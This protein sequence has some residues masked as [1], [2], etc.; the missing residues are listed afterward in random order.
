MFGQMHQDFPS[1]RILRD[2]NQ[3]NHPP[4]VPRLNI[5][6]NYNN[7]LPDIIVA[8]VNHII[9]TARNNKIRIYCFNKLSD[10]NFQ[11]QD[12]LDLIELIIG[13]TIL[14]VEY[15]RANIEDA[16]ND[17][18]ER[19]CT[20]YASKEV[21]NNNNLHQYITSR[22]HEDWIRDNLNE[23]NQKLNMINRLTSG[24]GTN[25]SMYGYN[26]NRFSNTGGSFGGHN[27]RNQNSRFPNTR[28]NSPTMGFQMFSSNKSNEQREVS[29]SRK[30]FNIQPN[31]N[32][33]N[34]PQQNKGIEMKD[35]KILEGLDMNGNNFFGTNLDIGSIMKKKEITLNN[36]T[37]T[38]DEQN[39][40]S[41]ITGTTLE[42]V[43]LTT[44]VKH[45]QV[46][47][48]NSNIQ[49]FR[50][51]GIVCE[52]IIN[53]TEVSKD[54]SSIL[55]YT[56]NNIAGINLISIATQLKNLLTIH[57][58]N[59]DTD[60]Q[61]LI[62]LIKVISH[63]NNFLTDAI[64]E[65]LLESLNGVAII[66]S[67]IEDIVDLKNVLNVKQKE[68]LKGWETFSHNAIAS[69]THKLEDTDYQ[70][71]IENIFMD[72]EKKDTILLTKIVT[73]TSLNMNYVQFGC[74]VDKNNSII[75]DSN[76]TP[77]VYEVINGIFSMKES[78]CDSM[79]DYIIL[80]DGVHLKIYKDYINNNYKLKRIK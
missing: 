2:L 6:Q 20:Y 55:G 27:F 40:L 19:G 14:N 70:L 10:N 29:S 59:I 31:T 46:L 79:E 56:E 78:E 17:A 60:K 54:I 64:N 68:V 34:K 45:I 49:T 72:E 44:K 32:V 48:K 50:S 23:M 76:V 18:I 71:T 42:D 43:L 9:L 63:I 1:D 80:N 52:P 8:L 11:N 25:Q 65:F 51:Y 57:S 77:N 24:G 4:F 39:V 41:F 53:K 30:M 33:V 62:D 47:D 74:L 37:A 15:D 12:F 22:E 26:D 75:V 67:F 69:L 5:P 36:L 66:D 28:P 16:V 38:S 61:Y 13:L 3:V 73:A 58:N 7:I 21:L 35:K